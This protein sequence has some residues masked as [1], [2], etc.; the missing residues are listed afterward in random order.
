MSLETR[1]TDES[2]NVLGNDEAVEISGYAGCRKPSSGQKLDD[3]RE[4]AQPSRT[5]PSAWAPV[6]GRCFAHTSSGFRARM[7]APITR[8]LIS[9]ASISESR[10]APSSNAFASANW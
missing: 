2:S 7:N 9:R 10:P 4:I 8:P 3:G 5:E 1:Y 6:F